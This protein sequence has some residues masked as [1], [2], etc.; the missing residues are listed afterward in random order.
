MGTVYKKTVTRKVP[1]NA[2][3]FIKNGESFV[4]YKVRGRTRV[5]RLVVGEDGTERISE[6]SSTYIAKFKDGTGLVQEVST[7]CRDKQ[8]A[9]SV[10]DELMKRAELVKAKIMTS[11]FS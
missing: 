2:E 6:Q 4:R 10:L 11:D 8:A 3:R 1:A 7:G 9:F 5:S